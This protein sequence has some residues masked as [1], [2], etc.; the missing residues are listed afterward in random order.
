[1]KDKL[2]LAE[3]ELRTNFII[4]SRVNIR[5]RLWHID[6]NIYEIP[7]CNHCKIN[8]VKWS[9]KNQTY[10]KF[11]SSKC[12]SVS[13]DVK[14]QRAKTCLLKYGHTTNLKSEDNK[15]KQQETCLKKYGVTNFSKS[16]L[17]KERFIETCIER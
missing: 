15:T 13:L 6:N 17:F 8:V 16:S 10:S 1:M 7:K 14:E 12:S 3:I 11:C 9:I 2:W 5:Q 4:E